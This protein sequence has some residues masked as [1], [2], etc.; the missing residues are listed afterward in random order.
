MSA[1]ANT[2]GQTQGW[3]DLGKDCPLFAFAASKAFVTK[4]RGSRDY[5]ERKEREVLLSVGEEKAGGGDT[6][7]IFSACVCVCA[8][9]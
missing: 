3:V 7:W 6:S 1:I 4:K 9:V 5:L 2:H 8:C